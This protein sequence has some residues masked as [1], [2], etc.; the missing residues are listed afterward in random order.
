MVHQAA[1]PP[2]LAGRRFAAG[3]ERRSQLREAGRPKALGF[4]T[5]QQPAEERDVAGRGVHAREYALDD[6]SRPPCD[7]GDGACCGDEVP[8]EQRLHA[9]AQVERP[10]G[11]EGVRDA[12]RQAKRPAEGADPGQPPRSCRR[13]CPRR[14]GPGPERLGVDG[15]PCLVADDG[16]ILPEVEVG[17]ELLDRFLPPGYEVR[18]SRPQQPRGERR[19]AAVGPGHREALEQGTL[20]EEVE[21]G[22]VEV[23]RVLK[24]GAPVAGTRPGVGQPRQAAVVEGD[25]ALEA[26]ALGFDPVEPHPEPEHDRQRGCD[27]PGGIADPADDSHR[28]HPGRA[29]PS[30]AP[31]P[32]LAMPAVG[33]GVGGLP[34]GAPLGVVALRIGRF[35]R[36]DEEACSTRTV[37]TS[38]S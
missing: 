32:Q 7:D 16:E 26:G 36:H 31:Q 10:A 29:E 12:R 4:Q 30:Q 21:V 22:C 28:E 19:P 5:R 33:G 1:Q 6:G 25:G 38:V 35:C 3:V 37:T 8:P 11:R 18:G 20:A 13:E 15:S 34:A 17:R 24:L 9:G 27:P 14:A 23:L 2:H